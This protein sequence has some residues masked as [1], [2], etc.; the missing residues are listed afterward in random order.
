LIDFALS[1]FHHVCSQP[2]WKPRREQWPDVLLHHP[3]SSSRQQD[4]GRAAFQHSVGIFEKH[5]SLDRMGKADVPQ[6][7]SLVWTRKLEEDQQHDPYKVRTRH[8]TQPAP[9]QATITLPRW[10][11]SAVI[12]LTK[13]LFSTL[14]FDIRDTIQ[15]KTHAQVLLKKYD[16]GEYIYDQLDRH[17][18]SRR[19]FR[20]QQ[21]MMT[22]A[23]ILPC[24]SNTGP[25][26]MQSFPRPDEA[27]AAL[28][29][30]L[31]SRGEDVI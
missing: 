6:R 12:I 10:I 18:Q 25:L 17:Y 15:I 4:Y 19:Q 28:A 21:Q 3:S 23:P 5:W 11:A 30:L 8:T 14:L 24:G 22:P 13:F 1:F 31:L 29:M 20:Q 27:T 2:T 16:D 26:A 9:H 7:S